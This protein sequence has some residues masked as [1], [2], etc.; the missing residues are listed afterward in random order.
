[1]DPSSPDSPRGRIFSVNHFVAHVKG[2]RRHQLSQWAAPCFFAVT[3]IFQEKVL[4]FCVIC[5]KFLWESLQGEAGI[6][7]DLSDKK[8]QGFIVQIALPQ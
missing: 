8:A 5:C 7:L 6:I 4:D 2:V 3:S 1:M